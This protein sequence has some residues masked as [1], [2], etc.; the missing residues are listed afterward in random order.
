MKTLIIMALTLALATAEEVALQEFTT[1]NNLFTAALYKEV[2][3]ENQGNFLVSPFSIETVLALTHSGA[4]DETAYEIR[5]GLRLPNS[6]EKTEAV[7][8][9]LLPT[10]KG[11]DKYALHTANKIYVKDGYP[12]KEDFKNKAS[13]VFQSGIENIEFT[14]K[15]D[16]ANTINSWVG[17]QTNNK[18]QNLIDPNILG[19]D[20]RIILINA[21]YFKG[22]WV[23]PFESDSTIKRDFYKTAKDVV[24]VDMMHNTDVYNYYESPELKAKFLEMPYEGDDLSMVIVLPNEKEGLAALE[25][26]IENVF[27]AP[28]FTQERVSVSLPKFTVENKIQLKKILQN[29]GINKAFSDEADLSG[30]AGKKGDLAISDVIQKAF[31][32]VTETG[33]E[34]AAATAASVVVTLSL[35]PQYKNIQKFNADHPFLF[36]L[37]LKTNNLVLFLGKCNTF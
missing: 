6:T 19:P 15:V 34:A 16:A 26:Q 14:Q 24:Q 10:L 4:K 23:Y 9:T 3:K 29:L 12:L 36:Y 11:N 5:A 37:K 33:T 1:G 8:A 22:K 27:A 2:L 20:T 25:S 18:I 28:R 30:L 17:K 31:I 7:Y 13:T 35:P 21:L 32:N